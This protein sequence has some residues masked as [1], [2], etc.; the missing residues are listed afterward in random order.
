MGELLHSGQNSF[1]AFIPEGEIFSFC[2]LL[3]YGLSFVCVNIFISFK[4]PFTWTY[5]R[6]FTNKG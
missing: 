1:I 4:N 5:F 6:N 2:S 3:F